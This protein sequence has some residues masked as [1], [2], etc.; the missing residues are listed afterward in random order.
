MG[1]GTLWATGWS[2]VGHR[3]RSRGCI[4]GL[5]GLAALN[6]HLLPCGEGS[7]G[8]GAGRSS[9]GHPDT[10]FHSR[11]RRGHG[12][13]Q[14]G[15]SSPGLGVRGRVSLWDAWRPPGPETVSVNV[16]WQGRG[17]TSCFVHQVQ[18]SELSGRKRV[19]PSKPSSLPVRRRLW[20]L[21]QALQLAAGEQREAGPPRPWGRGNRCLTHDWPRAESPLFLRSRSP[22][23]RPT[24]I[25]A[26]AWASS[27][28]GLASLLDPAHWAGRLRAPLFVRCLEGWP[29]LGARRREEAHAGRGRTGGWRDSRIRG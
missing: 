4:Q 9:S 21:P 1:W 13:S 28:A 6:L 19:G 8:S 20:P 29:C 24:A 12:A 22:V 16:R 7:W 15:D 2:P 11:Q 3:G 17:W 26:P 23:C 14:A 5:D 25:S 10:A 18:S 27:V